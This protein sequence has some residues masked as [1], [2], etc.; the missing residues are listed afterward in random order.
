MCKLTFGSVESPDAANT[1]EIGFV[2][3]DLDVVLVV[4]VDVVVVVDECLAVLNLFFRF[5]AASG[6]GFCD[7]LAINNTPVS[8][9]LLRHGAVACRPET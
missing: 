9:P 4:L 2:L 7:F 3:D 5:I 6:N 1:S 8:G